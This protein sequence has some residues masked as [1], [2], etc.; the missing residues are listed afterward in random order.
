[1]IVKRSVVGIACVLATS[2]AWAQAPDL[3]RMDIV[4][5]SMPDGP[6]AKVHGTNISRETFVQGYQ[7]ELI[8]AARQRGSL[9][10][11]DESRASLAMRVLGTLVERELLYKEATQTALTVTDESVQKAWESQRAQL[12]ES[13]AASDAAAVTEEELLG[14]LGV[15]SLNAVLEQV[16]RALLTEKM[17]ATI[18]RQAEFSIDDVEVAK[19]FEARNSGM[20]RPERLHLKQIFINPELDSTGGGPARNRAEEALER[21]FSGQRFG[22]VAREYSNSPDANAGGDLGILPVDQLPPFMVEAAASMEPGD[23]SEVLESEFGV[24]LIMLVDRQSAASVTLE[25]AAPGI[26]RAMLAQRGAQAVR[27]HCDNL[28]Q[29]GADVK[30]YLELDKNLA[31]THGVRGVEEE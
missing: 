20:A 9:D 12:L 8:R 31:L 25:E 13:L 27:E 5:K 19:V 14:L 3:E 28:I 15:E 22:A 16:R 2:V 18:I 30:I 24:H 26:R 17:R 4:L 1:M 11:S 23:V 10:L 6:V 21:I 29:S 7:Q